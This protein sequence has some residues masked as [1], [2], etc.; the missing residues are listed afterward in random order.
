MGKTE[1]N[2][3]NHILD[4]KE[5]S[6]IDRRFLLKLIRYILR[7]YLHH[8]FFKFV[9]FV[10][11]GTI[12]SYDV[13]TQQ[14]KVFRET[15]VP[16]F[17]PNNFNVNQ[18]FYRSVDDTKVPMY[19]ISKKDAVL[20]G[21]LPT[22]LYG[23]GGFNISLNPSFSVSRLLFVQHF[24]GIVAVPN[25]RGGG[26]YGG[27][28]HKAGQRNNKQNVFNDFISAAQYLIH[29]KYTNPSKIFINGGSN[30]G[31]L[32]GA[33]INQRPDLFGCAVASVGVM[34]MLHFHKFTIGHAWCSDY[35]CADIKEEFDALY[36]YSPLHNVRKGKPYP[37][38]LLTTADHDDRVVP[39]H[40]FKL[41]SELQ[42]QLGNETQQKQPLLIRI[43]T[44]AGHGAGK[45]LSKTI[46]ELADV[47]AFVG[48]TLGLTWK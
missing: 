32:V 1:R 22:F 5:S 44:K 29:N 24:N 4:I 36:A 19:I 9:S 43:E 11:P 27:D 42:Y 47:F 37:A 33:C 6:H 21:N 26:E 40:S 16:G 17:D 35:G 18:V 12:F 20:D 39:L 10:Y 41:I 15:Q 7:N 13:S 25:L 34:D 2:I 23:Y 45:P 14:M 38:T 8:F 28:W 3:T 48:K 30:G 46:E 31:L